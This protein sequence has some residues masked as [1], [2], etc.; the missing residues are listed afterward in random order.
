MSTHV[1]SVGMTTGSFGCGV[2]AGGG[3]GAGAGSGST[4]GLFQIKLSPRC[5]AAPSF[6]PTSDIWKSTRVI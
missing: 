2:G 3:G 5:S 6:C 4:L 1:R